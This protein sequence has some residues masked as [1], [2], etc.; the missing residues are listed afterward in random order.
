M[1]TTY[2]GDQTLQRPGDFEVGAVYT[3]IDA[4]RFRL[5]ATGIVRFPTGLADRPDDFFDVG[6]GQGQTDIEGRLTADFVRGPLG[7]RLSAGYNRQLAGTLERRIS[8][9]PLA[10]AATLAE[11][12]RDPGDEMT[13]GFEPFLRLAP[14]FALTLGVHRW[15]RGAEEFTLGGGGS[16]PGA[17]P[18]PRA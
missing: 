1:R 11:V 10:Y 16:A 7:A 12:S 6:T 14:G 18:K 5:A 9:A 2:R 15:S 8:A 17:A 3:L 4:P 13:L